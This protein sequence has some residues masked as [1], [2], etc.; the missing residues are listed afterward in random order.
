MIKK[1]KNKN[2]NDKLLNSYGYGYGRSTVSAGSKSAE[3]Q[4]QRVRSVMLRLSR[5][6]GRIPVTAVRRNVTVQLSRVTSRGTVTAGSNVK[7]SYHGLREH[8]QDDEH[9]CWKRV[10]EPVIAGYKCSGSTTTIHGTTYTLYL[11]SL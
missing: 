11:V 7:F 4:L 2:I 9:L 5:V 10:T 1:S 6:A 3:V 8:T